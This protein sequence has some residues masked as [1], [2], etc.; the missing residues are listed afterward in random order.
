MYKQHCFPILYWNTNRIF[1]TI[2]KLLK[3]KEYHLIISCCPG[4][5]SYVIALKT[6]HNPCLKHEKQ[7]A[8]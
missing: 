2:L 1:L 5:M 8:G 3:I 6:Y 7:T 4:V